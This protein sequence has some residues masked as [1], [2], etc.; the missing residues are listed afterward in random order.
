[1]N[2][3]ISLPPI[4]IQKEIVSELE[5]YKKI[6]DGAKQILDNYKP[7]IKIDTKWEQVPIG[8]IAKVQGGFAFKS[9]DMTAESGVQIIKIGNVKNQNF[10]LKKSPSFIDV[11]LFKN[12]PD[13]QLS[14][15]DILISMTGTMGKRDYGNVC[16]VDVEGKFLLNQR[17]GRIIPN[18]KIISNYLFFI[19]NRNETKDKFYSNATGGVRQGNIS[20]KQ[21]EAIKV[22]LPPIEIQKQI[23]AKIEEEQ[24][25]IE[26]NKGLAK[27][28]EQK[29]KD[30][31]S[32]IW[33]E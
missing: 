26:I 2:F 25:M 13:Y 11:E 15:G 18:S 9:Q 22:P 5:S 19:L 12:Y 3:K 14:I 17:V 32:E 4:E 27:L 24:K 29:I 31:I 7:A 6:I 1:M 30:K 20:S 28:F 8:D 16:M 33:G 10:D 21:I 23:V